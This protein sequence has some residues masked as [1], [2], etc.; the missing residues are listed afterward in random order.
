MKQSLL[1][2]GFL[3]FLAGITPQTVYSQTENEIKARAKYKEGIQLMDNGKY[4]ESIN[5]LEEAWQL[6]PEAITIQYEIAYAYY[7]N[8]KY[9][10]ANNVLEKYL[11]HKDVNFDF[12]QLLGN[13]YDL[14]G[15]PD[16]A[17]ETYK[18]GLV[19]FPKSGSLYLE[20]GNVQFNKQ[21]YNAALQS[22]ESGINAE[23]MFPSNYYRAAKLYCSTSESFWGMMYGEIYLNIDT[24]TKRKMEISKL[25]YDTYKK[26]VTYKND[27]SISI[28]FS[29]IVSVKIDSSSGTNVIKYPVNFY[30]GKSF[31]MAVAL[32]QQV[33]NLKNLHALRQ[34]TI[35]HY[36]EMES[37]KECPNVLIEFQ[38]KILDAG[39]FEAYNYWLLMNGEE[40]TF[41]KWYK[42]NKDKYIDFAKWLSSNSLNIDET[43]KFT[44]R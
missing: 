33:I 37:N 5:S 13:S 29:K 30:Y 12:F 27:T 19:K 7:L 22:Y 40:E 14:M 28:T 20:M 41:Q 26:N 35:E 8:K 4:D 1:L 43:N 16:K 44:S 38:K 11:T 17:I 23:P 9:E 21:D 10:K 25:L 39:H 18:Q 36:Y 34:K 31:A 6:M 32:G 2:I 3:I 42:E 24:N 15:K